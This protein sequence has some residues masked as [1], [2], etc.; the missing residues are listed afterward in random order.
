MKTLLGALAALAGGWLLINLVG[1][2]ADARAG[3][4]A[5]IEDTTAGG[6]VRWPRN[7]PYR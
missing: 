3:G 4:A 6:A 2:Q 7:P 5:R 1:A